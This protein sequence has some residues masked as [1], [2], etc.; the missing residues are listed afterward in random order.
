[1][2][3]MY[4]STSGTCS[5]SVTT[6]SWMPISSRAPRIGSNSL[7]EWLYFTRKPRSA[8]SCFTFFIAG[9]STLLCR[10]LIA[11]NASL[12]QQDNWN[13]NSISNSNPP[14]PLV[15]LLR[16]ELYKHK[17]Y[18]DLLSSTIIIV[19][20]KPCG[21]TTQP[22]GKELLACNGG[23]NTCYCSKPCQTMDWKSHQLECKSYQQSNKCP[24]KGFEPTT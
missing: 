6:L 8:Y 9:S 7:A 21:A 5:A 11:S 2:V 19:S 20:C 23:C 1:M 3:R 22:D 18:W 13:W 17:H 12:P 16:L 4:R 10:L 24:E 15:Q 14:Q